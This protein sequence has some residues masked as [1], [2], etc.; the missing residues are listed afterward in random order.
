MGRQQQSCWGQMQGTALAHAQT[1]DTLYCALACSEPR[2]KHGTT[3]HHGT[4]THLLRGCVLQLLQ[5]GQLLLLA[6]LCL[7]L[8]VP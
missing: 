5:Q 7:G 2:P 1:P 6:L 4:H 3:Q 8:Q